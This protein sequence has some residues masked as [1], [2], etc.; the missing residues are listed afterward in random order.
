MVLLTLGT[1]VGGAAMVDG[2]ILHGAT[3]IAGHFG[4]ITVELTGAFACAAIMVAWKPCSHRERS[5]LTTSRTCIEPQPVTLPAGPDGHI[6]E[7]EAIFR[8]AAH[9]DESARCV[10]ERALE[11]LGAA[12][13]SLLHAFDPEVLILGGSIAQADEQVLG[14]MRAAIAKNSCEM[15]GREVPVVVQSAV[16]YGGVLGAAGL[17]FLH[18]R[19]LKI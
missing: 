17:I 3:G 16:G 8:A 5:R 7:T 18:Q 19:I 2:V 13:V 15:L 6:P 1:G 9:G 14:P 11:Y 12:V 10:L 4:H